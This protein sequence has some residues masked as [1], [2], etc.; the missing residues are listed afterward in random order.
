[1]FASGNRELRTHICTHI[2]LAFNDIRVGDAHLPST[3]CYVAGGYIPSH[4][5]QLRLREGKCS[6]LSDS[7]A[8]GFFLLC[9]F[10]L[11]F[12]VRVLSARKS[13]S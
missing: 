2:H 12:C 1:M 11:F 9:H 10:G 13:Y 5:R 3:R 4:G 8:C 7:G 6:G